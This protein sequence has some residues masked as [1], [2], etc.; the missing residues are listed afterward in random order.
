MNPPGA[1]ILHTTVRE[2]LGRPLT[3]LGLVDEVAW[4]RI[5]AADTEILRFER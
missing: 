5:R 3:D 1:D 2:L 4:S